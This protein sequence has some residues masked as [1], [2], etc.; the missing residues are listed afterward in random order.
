MRVRGGNLKSVCYVCACIFVCVC[1][2]CQLIGDL[3]SSTSTMV[4]S[5]P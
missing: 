3:N 4:R 2:V 1:Q 5:S